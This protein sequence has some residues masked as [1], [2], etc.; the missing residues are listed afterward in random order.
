MMII[1]LLILK[2]KDTTNRTFEI[3]EALKYEL[4]DKSKWIPA[5]RVSNNYVD[6]TT[7]LNESGF[8]DVMLICSEITDSSNLD[9]DTLV[10]S[11]YVKYIVSRENRT[12]K[13]KLLNR[14]KETIRLDD[15]F[16]AQKRNSDYLTMPE[17]KFS[18]EHLFY[19][20][21]G[22]SGFSDYTVLVSEFTEGGAAP[23]AVAIHLTYQKDNKEVWIRHF[24]SVTNDDQSNIQ[25]KFAEAA[26]K[27]VTFLDGKTFIIMHQRN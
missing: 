24:A 7:Q 10:F 1:P 15:N 25:G 26:L 27:A 16:N 6:I 9:F 11:P 22:Y 23:Y 4:A 17:E 14:G 20:D 5:F 8:E 13:R 21:D 12:L 2:L 18:E 19:K 3:L